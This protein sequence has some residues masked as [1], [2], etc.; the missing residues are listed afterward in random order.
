L[1]DFIECYLT[2][3]LLVT[4]M[5]MIIVLTGYIRVIRD[6][7]LNIDRAIIIY[8]YYVLESLFKTA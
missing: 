5:D 8:Q 2:A 1:L 3:F 7:F 4:V 6:S